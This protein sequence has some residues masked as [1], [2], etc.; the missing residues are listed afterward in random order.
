VFATVEMRRV[1]AVQAQKTAEEQNQVL[2]SEVRRLHDEL[3]SLKKAIESAEVQRQVI[4]Q[5]ALQSVPEQY[6]Q[7]IIDASKES[8]VPVEIIVALGQQESGW[9]CEKLGDAGDTGC[10]QILPDTGAWA[11]REMDFSGSLWNPQTNIRV[12]AWVLRTFTDME[13]GDWARGLASYNAGPGA[14]DRAPIVSRG[15]AA[16]VLNRVVVTPSS[17]K[18]K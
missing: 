18:P 15:Y 2:Q 1:H 6:R 10:L 9:D 14:W 7:F 3:E 12:G 13:N 16:R 5:V 4:E 11:M 17:V 8:N